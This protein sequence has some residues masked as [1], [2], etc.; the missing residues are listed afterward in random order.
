MYDVL[1]KNGLIIDGTGKNGYIGD[2]AVL[3]EKIVKIA[4]NI[5]EEARYVIDAGEKIVCPG[6]ID[7]HTHDDLVFDIDSMD[8]PKLRQGVTTVITG[9]CGFGAAPSSEN[10]R[11]DLIDY[12]APILGEQVK[13]LLFE[14]FSDYLKHMEEI[15]KAINVACLIPHGA[16]YMC[17]N[18]FSNKPLEKNGEECEI[19]LLRD[20]MDAGALG[21]SFGLMYA[22]GCYSEQSEIEKL[23]KEVGEKGGIVTIHMKSESENFDKSILSAIQLSKNCKVPVEISHLKNVGRKYWGN[24]K[25]TLEWLEEQ[26]QSGADL[27]FDMY[28]YTMGSTTMAILFPTE[29][30]KDGVKAFIGQLSDLEIRERISR[31]LK[32]D[33]GEEDNLGL[34]CGWENVIISSVKTEKNFRLMGKSIKDIAEEREKQPE[35]T[36]M[37]LFCEEAG[38]AA[39]LLNHIAQEDMEQTLLFEK[40][41]VASDGLP[42][43]KV[44]HPRLYGTFPKFLREF[45]REKHLLTWEEAIYK[46]TLQAT[47]RFGIEKRGALE[48]GNFADIVIFN[49]WEIQDKAD[50]KEPRQYPEGIEHVIVNGSIAWEKGGTAVTGHG[51]LL[52]KI[53][54]QEGTI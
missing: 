25:K 42:G 29:Y 38:D 35:E 31:R 24:M 19:R 17:A 11:K 33:W 8:F 14:K 52:R 10:C 5:R 26:L 16:I 27:S 51:K 2:L 22:P 39:V 43:A 36:L 1:I 15:E 53:S 20:A 4:E 28:P 6:F 48:E 18:G 23:A 9:N 47:G 49:P 21:L 7:V 32:E 40:V 54:V 44:P 34:L 45:V 13:T 3:G 50:F 46:I 12:N 30:L 41:S 37:D